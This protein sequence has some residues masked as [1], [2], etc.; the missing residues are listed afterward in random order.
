MFVCYSFCHSIIQPYLRR[1][2]IIRGRIVL[3]C[4][5]L[6]SESYVIQLIR[7]CFTHSPQH[8]F[9]K[10]FVT[11]TILLRGFPYLPPSLY[12]FLF[13][14]H[15]SILLS[16]C[17]LFYFIFTFQAERRVVQFRIVVQNHCSILCSSEPENLP[18]ENMLKIMG[19]SYICVPLSKIPFD[20]LNHYFKNAF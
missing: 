15:S 12:S 11:E 13:S 7:I 9:L 4:F 14:M 5:T 3:L 1:K 18:R 20:L 2:K 16:P 17:I 10:G 19:R 8:R 6:W